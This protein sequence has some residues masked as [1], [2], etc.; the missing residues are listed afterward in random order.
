M[1]L[2]IFFSLS[3]LL[4]TAQAPA[5]GPVRQ[6]VEEAVTINAPAQKVWEAIKEPCS[7]KEWHP[8]VTDCSQEGAS[9]KGAKRKLILKNGGWIV[10]ELKNYND[11]RM[12]YSYKFNLDDMSAAKTIVHANQEIKVPV[13]PVANYSD[14]IE[15]KKI[16]ANTAKVIWKGAFYRAYMNNN[17]PP[18][19]NEAAATGT[20]TAFYR[21][22]LDNLKQLIEKP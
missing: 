22:G 5:H 9:N 4:W 8:E 7:I 6:K 12:M 17:P 15:V 13:L 21:S 18:E 2:I 20:V 10:E 1:R 16:D 19:M 11:K 3:M 14:S